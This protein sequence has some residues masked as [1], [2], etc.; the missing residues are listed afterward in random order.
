MHPINSYFQCLFTFTK[1]HLLTIFSKTT[2]L[3]T[4]VAFSRFLYL[5]NF[6][7]VCA[8]CYCVEYDKT[9]WTHL[10][11]LHTIYIYI[12][13]PLRSVFFEFDVRGGRVGCPKCSINLASLS[14]KSTEPFWERWGWW[15]WI[16]EKNKCVG[17]LW[18]QGTRWTH[19]RRVKNIHSESLFCLFEFTQHYLYQ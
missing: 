1:R 10:S 19:N 11:S 18:P 15:L 8:F 13:L 4:H 12:S 17:L 6:P 2:Q 7:V 14:T 9:R 5:C 3:Y 16:I